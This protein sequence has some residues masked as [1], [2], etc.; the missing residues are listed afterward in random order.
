MRDAYRTQR[1]T[2][3]SIQIC[4]NQVNQ[5]YIESHS[6]LNSTGSFQTDDLKKN[7]CHGQST[8]KIGVANPA[9]FKALPT[10]MTNSVDVF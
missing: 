6:L 8:M 5:L 4:A 1:T 2:A 10:V 7:H 3:T 9:I